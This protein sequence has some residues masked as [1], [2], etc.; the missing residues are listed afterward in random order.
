VRKTHQYEFSDA[1]GECCVDDVL[2]KDGV[3]PMKKG[4]GTRLKST[5]AR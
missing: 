3:G 1:R 5:P 2:H 4:F